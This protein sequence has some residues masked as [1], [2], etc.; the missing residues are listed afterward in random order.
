MREGFISSGW[1]DTVLVT[2]GE[3]VRIVKPFLDFKGG[4]MFHC[5]NI[6]H[7]DMG[8]MREFLVE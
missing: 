2:R 6:E 5:H 1:E 3:R 4:F 7:E 8:M